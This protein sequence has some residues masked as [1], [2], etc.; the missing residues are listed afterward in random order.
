MHCVFYLALNEARAVAQSTTAAAKL[1]QKAGVQSQVGLC[2]CGGCLRPHQLK[3]VLPP[4]CLQESLLEGWMGCPTPKTVSRRGKVSRAPFGGGSP[5]SSSCDSQSLSSCT[6]CRPFWRC[7]CCLRVIFSLIQHCSSH[8]RVLP[9]KV[10]LQTVADCWVTGSLGRHRAR[11][12]HVCP[13]SPGTDPRTPQ[14]EVCSQH[15]SLHCCG[16]RFTAPNT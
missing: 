8:E 10:A 3:I 14:G 16:D 1:A 12:M 4:Y 9:C 6:L 15:S 5:G 13:A 11:C 2:L 7:F